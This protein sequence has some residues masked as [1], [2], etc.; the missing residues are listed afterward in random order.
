MLTQPMAAVCQK[1]AA[2]IERANERER[3]GIRS[4][5]ALIATLFLV[6]AIATIVAAPAAEAQTDLASDPT[7]SPPQ[8]AILEEVVVTAEKYT[9]RLQDVPMS[10]TAISGGQL[11]DSQSFNLQDFLNKVPGLTMLG[12]ANG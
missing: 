11:V 5:L 12:G 2:F 9:E 1:N 6:A 7:G 8:S 4:P 3:A 10:L